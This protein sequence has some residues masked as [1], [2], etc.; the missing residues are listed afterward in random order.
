MILHH[1]VKRIGKNRVL[2]GGMPGGGFFRRIGIPDDSQQIPCFRILSVA[3]H[4]L[5]LIHSYYHESIAGK[6]SS[7][8]TQ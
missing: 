5:I 2:S 3:Q 4:T 8:G 1:I 6:K 7:A